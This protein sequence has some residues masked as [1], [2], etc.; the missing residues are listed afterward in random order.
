MTA[1]VLRE[2]SLASLIRVSSKWAEQSPISAGVAEAK[3]H[4]F[5]QQLDLSRYCPDG[6]LRDTQG[7]LRLVFVGSVE[8]R[9][10]FHVLLRAIR[11]VGPSHFSLRMVGATGNRQ[12]SRLLRSEAQGLSVSI[13]PGDSLP[14]Y[15][16]AELA[17]LP[18]LEDGFGF[19]AGEAMACGLPVIVSDQCG[20][21]EWVEPGSGWIVKAGDGEALATALEDALSKR[22]VRAAMGRISRSSAERRGG[23][24]PAHA[25]REWVWS[26]ARPGRKH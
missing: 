16:R 23:A 3:I 21:Q 7:P 19:A 11:R 15:H 22:P 20:A 6:S 13:A 2:Y 24:G 26:R 5:S 14:A 12:D 17:I 8:L 9:K 18:S 10:G 4:V 1:R 25:L